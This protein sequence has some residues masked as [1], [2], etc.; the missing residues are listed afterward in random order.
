MEVEWRLDPRYFDMW[1]RLP[2]QHLNCSAK[3]QSLCL[4]F[5]IS[6][7]LALGLFCSSFFA[8][9]N[10]CLECFLDFFL[11]LKI[12]SRKN[13]CLSSILDLSH[14][15]N[16]IVSFLLDQLYTFME[17]S[18]THGLFTS[19]LFSFKVSGFFQLSFYYCFICCIQLWYD[20]TCIF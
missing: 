10:E 16:V 8:A 1:C 14:N 18:L 6:F 15:F 5:S 12:F 4:Y 17:N 20:A 19:V 11:F 2:K 7:L 9:L 13:F 3:P